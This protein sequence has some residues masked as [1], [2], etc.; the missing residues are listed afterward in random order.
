MLSREAS[1]AID[2][3]AA[4]WALRCDEADLDASTQR[5]LD[6]WLAGDVRRLGAF[7]RA[8]AVLIHLRRAKALG[9]AFAPEEFAAPISSDSAAEQVESGTVAPIITRRRLLAGASAIAASG[10]L[11]FLPLG[12]AAATGFETGRG[13]IRVVPLADGSTVT[14][15]TSS[16]MLVTITDGARRVELLRGEALFKVAPGAKS[17]FVVDAGVATLRTTE[18][19]FA[20]CRLNTVPVEITVCAGNVELAG[21]AGRAP[22]LLHRNLQARLATD[23]SLGTTALAAETLQRKLAWQEGMLSFEDT[24]LTEAA[25]EFARYSDRRIRFAD[26]ATGAETIT[27]YFAANDP[28]GFARAASLSLGLTAEIGP[29]T[30]TLRRQIL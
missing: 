8:Q 23:G 6:V 19:T 22:R 11:A 30:I 5:E 20:V 27:G 16:A 29:E 10:L 28:Q 14:L 2:E 25:A 12:R 15:N 21:G 1:S 4:L 26:A 18:A 24:P 13:E 17:P 3:A 7:V 9:P